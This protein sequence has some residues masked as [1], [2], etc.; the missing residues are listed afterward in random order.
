MIGAGNV[1]T[2]ISRHFH[3]AGHRIACIYSRTREPAERLAAELDA[4]A[5]SDPGEVPGKADFYIF[6]VPDQ[7]V[8]DV[9]AKFRG[10][11]GTWLHTAGALSMDVFQGITDDFGVLYPIQSLSRDRTIR[12]GHIPFLVEASSLAVLE[13]IRDLAF[14]ISEKVEAYDSLTRLKIHLAAVF[15]N[16]FSNHMVQVAQQ[17]LEEA[18]IDPGL[19]GPLL[20]ETFLKLKE[21]DAKSAQTGPAVRGDRESMNKH[22]E[23]LKDHP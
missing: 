23:L 10:R 7:A 16:N 1:S 5:T 20:E 17:I 18:H 11:K 2:H 14:S 21:L 4:V 6:C 12:M 19:L 9:A 8:P 15:A 22:R 13:R 3:S